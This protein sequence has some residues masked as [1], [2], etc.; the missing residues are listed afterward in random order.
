MSAEELSSLAASADLRRVHLV[1]WRDLE[2]PEAGGSELH[3][4]MV[5]K[6]WAEAG[7]DVTMR[8]SYAVNHPPTKTRDGY[9]VVRR[10]GRYL[11][12]P[13]AA[14]NE[15]LRRTGPYDA[16]VEI[17][18]GMPFLSPLWS[19]VPHSVWLHHVH[20]EMWNMVLPPGLATVG[21][22]LEARLA[23]P[24]YRRSRIVTLCE[25]S[26]RELVDD[27]GF[28]DDLVSVVAPGID[29][30]FSPGGERSPTPLVVAV[31]RLAPVKRFDR[32][33]RVLAEVK[34]RHPDLTAVIAGEGYE[35]EALEEL[36]REVSGEGW[37]SLPGRVSDDE[38]VDL[39]RRA[40]VVTS[41]SAR[42]GWG[43]TITEAAACGT[44]AVATRISGHED[45]IADG[46]TGLLAGDER[47]MVGHLD[48]VLADEGL[49]RRLG[50]A[51]LERARGYT[52][53]ATATG[54]LKALVAAA[55]DPG[56]GRG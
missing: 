20:A 44:P 39:Y 17:W 25:S 45:A 34:P 23:P 38:I 41:A 6:R 24:V 27:L 21:R 36:V 33:I 4:H 14:V 46:V 9:R 7:L 47:E 28:R 37:I 42:E 19:R 53:D 2:D 12:F 26:R 22:V 3:A 51:A 30:R 31:G 35:R 43:M 29:A 16:L 32:L 55:H 15:A 50:V 52:W 11:V 8:T 40:W 5:C 48:A 49:R 18:N 13:R 54:T 1:A 10:A 56:A